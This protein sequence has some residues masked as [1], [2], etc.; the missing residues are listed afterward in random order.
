M[1][2]DCSNVIY[3]G[4]GLTD[5]FA[6]GFVKNNGGFIIFVYQTN[7]NSDIELMKEKNI[8]SLFAK[9]DYSKDSE[10]NQ[11]VKRLVK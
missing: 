3:I 10:I 7:D 1:N 5:S 9:A 8:V 4:H 2:D 6:M 11:T